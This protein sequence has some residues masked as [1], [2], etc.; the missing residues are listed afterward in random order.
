MKRKLWT[1]QDIEYL[2]QHFPDQPTSAVCKQ[3]G[4]SYNSV[5]GKAL[6]LRIHKSEAFRN[7][8]VL[9][10]RTSNGNR[11]G[12]TRFKPGQ[13]A[14]N[15]GM[16]GLQIG[17]QETQF[18]PGMLPH[19]TKYD[20]AIS[21][22][23]GYKYIRISKGKWIELH[24][25]VW[26]QNH[27]SIPHGHNVMFKDGDRMNCALE[28]LELISNTDKMIRNTVQ[29]YPEEIRETIRMKAVLTRTIHKHEK[30]HRS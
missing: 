6:N 16:K 13:R 14:W 17:G 27:G 18:K 2:R 8:P 12:S 5:A 25:H 7:D 23:N 1:D 21:V 22:R 28:N 24:R 20:G 4:R 30:H 9:S 19:N 15:K 10:G 3:L 26:I 11:G 29:R